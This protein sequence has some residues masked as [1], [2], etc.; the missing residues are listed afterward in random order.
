[1][2]DDAM[3]AIYANIAL[4]LVLWVRSEWLSVQ[5]SMTSQSARPFAR[6]EVIARRLELSGRASRHNSLYFR[7]RL[8]A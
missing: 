3:A 2:A 8:S 1:M 6:Q 4:R 5:R 7:E